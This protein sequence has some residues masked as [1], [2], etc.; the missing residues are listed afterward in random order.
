MEQTNPVK[1]IRTFC[2]KCCGD[3]PTDVK[4]CNSKNCALY[5]FRFGKNPYRKK[6]ELTDEQKKAAAAR[7]ATA[8]ERKD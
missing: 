5:A 1:A 2:L 3:S 7:L 8:R 4:F 6:R